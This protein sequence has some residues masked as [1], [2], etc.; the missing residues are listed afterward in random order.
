MRKI[1][2]NLVKQYIGE[3]KTPKEIACILGVHHT[4]IYSAMQRLGIEPGKPQKK[5]SRIVGLQAELV[6]VIRILTK[7]YQTSAEPRRSAVK[8]SILEYAKRLKV[9]FKANTDELISACEK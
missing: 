3:K 6:Y 2:D 4:T 1:N 7:I 8:K 5:V 9:E